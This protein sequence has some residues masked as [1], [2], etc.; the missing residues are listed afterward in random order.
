[1]NSSFLR[2]RL[3]KVNAN[4]LKDDGWQSTN[5]M[6]P[7]I[8]ATHVKNLEIFIK[9]DFEDLGE[10]GGISFEIDPAK[11]H[12]VAKRLSPVFNNKNIKT[13]EKVLHTYIDFFVNEMKMIG[14]EKS[15]KLCSWADWLIMDI[16]ADMIYNRQMNQMK[17]DK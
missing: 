1:M 3:G 14:G 5:R 17:N 12:E 13:K 6:F 10:D 7:D 11:H 8:H 16:S 2:R 15:V 9:T 4:D